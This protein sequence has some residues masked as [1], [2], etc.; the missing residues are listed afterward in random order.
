MTKVWASGK[1]LA[2]AKAFL[3]GQIGAIDA[4]WALSLLVNDIE[5]FVSQADRNLFVAVESETDD[6]PVSNLKENWHPQFLPAK[7]EQLAKYEAAVS[8]EVRDA[9]ERL[10]ATL[11]AKVTEVES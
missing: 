10:V 1:A 7:L 2:T 8:S 9:C 4:C 3:N 5:H 11:E 6:L